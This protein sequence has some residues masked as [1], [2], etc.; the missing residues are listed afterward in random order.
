MDI[1]SFL[2]KKEAIAGLDISDS[3]IRLC[4]F[5]QHKKETAPQLSIQK[6]LVLP[7]GAIKN[8]IIQDKEAVTKTLLS[9]FSSL[10]ETIRYVIVTIPAQCTY[11][12]LFKFPKAIQGKKLEDS[13]SL[14]IG[15]QLPIKMED[16]YLDW[17]QTEWHETNEVVLAAAKKTVIDAYIAV[18]TAAKLKTV[19]IEPNVFAILRTIDIPEQLPTLIVDETSADDTLFWIAHEKTVRFIRS[20]PKQPPTQQQEEIR[21]LTAFYEV[22]YKAAPVI[23]RLNE[24]TMR[25]D[26]I[27][28][29]KKQL[30][31]T[32]LACIGA[33]KRGVI[34]RAQDSLISL[35]PMGTAEAYQRQRTISFV[36][37]LAN[38]TIGISLFFSVAFIGTWAALSSLQQQMLSRI[39]NLSTIPIAPDT[40]ELEARAQT[41]NE[42]TGAASQTLQNIPHW[43][44]I[45][46]EIRKRSANGIVVT[47]AIFPSPEETLTITGTAT[48]RGNLIAFKK[49]MEE[50][51]LF[52]EV[53]LPPTNL[54]LRQAIPFSLSF[55]LKDPTSIYTQ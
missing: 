54:E 44:T 40:A 20:T 21:K 52:T 27:P 49:N 8:G 17:E 45:I 48:D 41:L 33:A 12:K 11:V 25:A 5:A 2:T 14:T 28:G 47:N 55:K 38:A 32:W 50:S 3:H 4:F 51:L 36:E 9:L 29:Q 15:F 31:S 13:M 22:E 1:V 53:S 46:R 7:A 26:A 37:F 24:A 16:I 6:E 23:L 30:D 34:P 43:S 35:M 10:P 18:L 42:L 39:E 19:A